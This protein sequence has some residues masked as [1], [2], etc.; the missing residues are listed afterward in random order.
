MIKLEILKKIIIVGILCFVQLLGVSKIFAKDI[1]IKYE[2]PTR[3][4]LSRYHIN[5]I[6]F[7]SSMVNK[8]VGYKNLYSSIL[9]NNKK[10][11]YLR[12]DPEEPE[13]INIS[14]IDTAGR[15]FDFELEQKSR[16]TPLSVRVITER[17]GLVSRRKINLEVSKILE[18]MKLE[19]VG[20]YYVLE[21]EKRFKY[22]KLGKKVGY[23]VIKDYRWR[24]LRGLG[25]EVM[26]RSRDAVTIRP[27]RFAR[28]NYGKVI[29]GF[30][31]ETIIKPKGKEIVY[32]VV[33]RGET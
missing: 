10:D 7:D 5:R 30:S 23:R 16:K 15:V 13:P 20:K 12:L 31:G 21:S 24:N 22:G 28:G 32:L 33:D 29:G 27:K 14:V 18:A 26:N 11:L 4:R 17:Q 9:S 6:H 2:S 1:T 3:L 25:I 8:V 19:L